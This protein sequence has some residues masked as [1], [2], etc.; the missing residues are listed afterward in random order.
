MGKGLQRIRQNGKRQTHP[1]LPLHPHKK[2][3]LAPPRFMGERLGEGV[4]MPNWVSD[5][6]SPLPPPA[7]ERG[8]GRTHRARFA[9][10]PSCP[11]LS[12]AFIKM[13]PS[14]PFFMGERIK[15]RG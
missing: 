14:P 7:F 12:Q 10:R 11:A 13:N 9:F 3:S 6:R 15:V 2:L 4:S 5:N 8:R 1:T